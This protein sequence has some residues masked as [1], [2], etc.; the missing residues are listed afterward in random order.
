MIKYCVFEHAYKESHKWFT[1][2]NFQNPYLKK[3]LMYSD[4]LLQGPTS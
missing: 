2:A 1:L 4:K 3:Y